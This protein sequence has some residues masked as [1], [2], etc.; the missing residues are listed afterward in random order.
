[1]E[2]GHGKCR[3]RTVNMRPG[4]SKPYKDVVNKE[5]EVLRIYKKK[6]GKE[7][8]VATITYGEEAIYFWVAGSL[9]GRV[10]SEVT[11]TTVA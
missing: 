2:Q 5:G 8:L 6:G 10:L 7:A 4:A 11:A 1:M 3:F 9:R